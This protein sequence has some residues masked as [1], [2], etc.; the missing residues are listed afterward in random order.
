M[1]SK[2]FKVK[3]IGEPTY[4]PAPEQGEPDGLFRCPITLQST[5]FE[6]EEQDEILALLWDDLSL[7]DIKTG[8]QVLAKLQFRLI[9]R[10]DGS[11]YQIADVVEISK[12]INF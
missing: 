11:C 8:D 2:E 6:K 3:N 10:A 5:E 4:L 9:S 12:L 1:E 7:L